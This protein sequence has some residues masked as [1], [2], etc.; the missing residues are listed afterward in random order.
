M[1]KSILLGEPVVEMLMLILGHAVYI[2]RLTA[3]CCLQAGQVIKTLNEHL[4]LSASRDAEV[5][6]IPRTAQC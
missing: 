5:M 6:L 2:A 4:E 3:H 1:T